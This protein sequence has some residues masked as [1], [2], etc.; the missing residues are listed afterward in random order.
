MKVLYADLEREWRGGQS[1]ALLTV[2][3]LR[4]R[5]HQVELLAAKDSP[6]AQRASA[7]GI[8]VHQVSRCGLRISAV[9]K[10][11]ALLKQNRYEI[12]HLNE[13]HAL[14]AAWMAQAHKKLPLVISRRIGHPLWQNWVSR[15]RFDALSRFLATSEEIK[16]T[17]IDSH[18]PGE[19]I[20]IVNEGVEITPPITDEERARARAHFGIQDTQFLFGNVAVFVPE[21]GQHHLIE[22][23][24]IVRAKYPETRVLLA[25]DGA[26]RADLESLA[27]RLGQQDA[28]L[29]PG[30]LRDVA[31]VYAALDAFAFPSE[32]EGLGTSLLVALA[33]G[34]PV[35]STHQGSL[36]EVVDHE[37]TG[38]A[39]KPNGP[40]FAAAML[41]LIE[42]AALRQ[43][44]GEEARH[45]A[46]R[47]FSVARMVEN[48]VRIYEDVLG[49]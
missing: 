20:S 11:R 38:L 36:A 6:L 8:A 32:Y 43:R 21:K 2:R 27:K 23:L 49:S 34:L 45:E 17:L 33:M 40:E 14:T 16:Q 26:C 35:I 39:A 10:L 46:E 48:T 3:G 9:L 41:R 30:F 29:F 28:V 22:A 44:I 42:D 15:A 7:A 13:A 25:G 37:R 18:I 5:G 1:Q 4:E 47:R 19:K 12:I 31:Q 24:P